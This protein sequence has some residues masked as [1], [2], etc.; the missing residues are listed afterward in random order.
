MAVFYFP[1]EILELRNGIQPLST[2][3]KLAGPVKF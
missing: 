2:P 3:V 1:Y